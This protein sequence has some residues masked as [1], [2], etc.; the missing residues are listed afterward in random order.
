MSERIS[1]AKLFNNHNEGVWEIEDDDIAR[2]TLIGID[3]APY[4]D[5]KHD[6]YR[7]HNGSGEFDFKDDFDI[8]IVHGLKF[9]TGMIKILKTGYLHKTNF[10][11]Q[12]NSHYGYRA[13]RLK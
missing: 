10:R 5:W 4:F 9:K 12:Y 7:K 1:V 2:N 13:Q 3:S 8:I 6:I 11:L